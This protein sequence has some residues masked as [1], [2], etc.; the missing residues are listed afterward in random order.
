MLCFVYVIVFGILG[1]FS[2]SHRQL[3]FESL[4]CIKST[5]RRQPCETKV[6]QKVKAS[7]VHRVF[8]RSPWM[9]KF[10][11]KHFQVIAWT[12]ILLTLI[13]GV[14][15]FKSGYDLIVHGTCTPGDPTGCTISQGTGVW[16]YLRGIVP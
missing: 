1:I 10:L 16:S 13:T 8:Q 9:A 3:F 15:S 12:F 6:D 7:L 11:N 4:E 14:L 2:A 5:F